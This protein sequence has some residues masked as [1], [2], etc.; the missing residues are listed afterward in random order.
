M[1]IK[2]RVVSRLTIGVAGSGVAL[3]FLLFTLILFREG[4]PA[5]TFGLLMVGTF[6]FFAYYGSR[7]AVLQAN[8]TSIVYRP[9]VGRAHLVSRT[10]LASIERTAGL[11]G[12][13]YF[14]FR[15]HDGQELFHAGETY[16]RHNMAALAS[17]LGVPVRWELTP[18]R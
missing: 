15:S 3:C 9:T 8:E 6:G 2:P 14:R 13:I 10:Q 18:V 12:T 5:A 11:K 7:A 17:S 16:S 4:N 1:V